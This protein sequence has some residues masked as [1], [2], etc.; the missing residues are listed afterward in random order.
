MQWV[1]D[2]LDLQPGNDWLISAVDRGPIT[3]PFRGPTLRRSDVLGID[4]SPA[5]LV[6]AGQRGV[7]AGITLATLQ[8]DAQRLPLADDCCRRVMA[9]HILYHVPDQVAALSEMARIRRLRADGSC[10]SPRR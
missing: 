9:N 10:W 1:L 5:M 6:E 2:M 7:Q 3:M 8:A 4:M